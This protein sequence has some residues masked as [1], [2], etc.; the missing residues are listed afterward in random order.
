VYSRNAGFLD[1]A[2]ASRI[3]NLIR[4]LGFHLF[5]HELLAANDDNRLAVLA[6]LEEFREHLGGKLTITLLE[7]I[8]RGVEVNAMDE[9]KI[10]QAIHELQGCQSLL[11]A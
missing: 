9:A 1:A 11:P 3:L 8:G 2:S 6:G 7:G 10:V 4:A 5:A